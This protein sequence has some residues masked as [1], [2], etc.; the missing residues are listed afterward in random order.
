MAIYSELV[1]KCL[2]LVQYIRNFC[3]SLWFSTLLQAWWHQEGLCQVDPWL[4]CFG[5]GKQDRHHL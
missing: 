3:C 5:R 2:A 1:E 4:R